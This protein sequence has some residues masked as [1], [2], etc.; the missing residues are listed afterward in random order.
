ME[1]EGESSVDEWESSMKEGEPSV[2]AE[3]LSVEE[4]SARIKDA[5]RN[6]RNLVVLD[7]L[8]TLKQW[9][10]LQ[11]LFPDESRILITTRDRAVA[12]STE[13]EHSQK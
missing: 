10:A 11:N 2:E 9:N 12:L 7:N 3:E 8:R 4:L 5:L 13:P 6:G 1:K